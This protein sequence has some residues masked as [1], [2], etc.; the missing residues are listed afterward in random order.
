MPLIFHGGGFYGTVKISVTSPSTKKSATCRVRARLGI[1]GSDMGV[2]SDADCDGQCEGGLVIPKWDRTLIEAIR[3]EKKAVWFTPELLRFQLLD[4]LFAAHRQQLEILLSYGQTLASGETQ[5]LQQ[6]LAASREINL[7]CL[8]IKKVQHRQKVEA[9]LQRLVQEALEAI[10]VRVRDPRKSEALDYLSQLGTILDSTGRP[11]PSAKAAMSLAAMKRLGLR[12]EVV[13]TVQPV[14]VYRKTV[15]ENY[16]QFLSMSFETMDHFLTTILTNADALQQSDL[17]LR[18]VNR[19]KQ[20]ARELGCI[21]VRPFLFSA[22]FLIDEFNTAVRVLGERKTDGAL[23]VLKRSRES[24]K[25][26]RIRLDLEGIITEIAKIAFA[27][28]AAIAGNDQERFLEAVK[29]IDQRL[30]GVDETGFRQPV[31]KRSHSHL[32]AATQL[33][34][35]SPFGLT[36]LRQ[37]KE[38]LK[39]A[40]QPI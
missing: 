37:V 27:K 8:G 20:F 38:S 24:L 3:K 12:Q 17:K 33:L 2:V 23:A 32:A 15:L 40:A 18:T 13:W 26:R 11:N 28:P 14:I 25:L 1:F 21:D 4:D 31:T 29:S 19:L 10:G 9:D 7:L 16:L 39:T 35:M 36:E 34:R 5:K 30:T 6:A 22:R